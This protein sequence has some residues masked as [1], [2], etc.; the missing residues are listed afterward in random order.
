MVTYLAIR[1][2]QASNKLSPPHRSPP[3]PR[4]GL[5]IPPP[6]RHHHCPLVQVAGTARD[7]SMAGMVA[8]PAPGEGRRWR[9]HNTWPILAHSS[10]ELA[11]CF[12]LW[13]PASAAAACQGW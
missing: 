4:R 5:L 3:L 12:V 7:D 6:R 13:C 10:T 1:P 8:G 11:G 9:H 2:P